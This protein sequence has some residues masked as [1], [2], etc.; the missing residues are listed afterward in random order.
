M[1]CTQK[2][3]DLGWKPKG[4]LLGSFYHHQAPYRYSQVSSSLALRTQSMTAIP[5]TLIPT[6]LSLVYRFSGSAMACRCVHSW[7]SDE[8]LTI[9]FWTRINWDCS[10]NRVEPRRHCR[11]VRPPRIRLCAR[12]NQ[13]VWERSIVRRCPVRRAGRRDGGASVL[14][15]A[16]LDFADRGWVSEGV[17]VP[18][19]STLC[20]PSRFSYYRPY[21]VRTLCR[22][23]AQREAALRD[24]IS[25][26][27]DALPAREGGRLSVRAQYLWLQDGLDYG[28]YFFK[29]YY[30]GPYR[31]VSLQ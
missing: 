15:V 16:L 8:L 6:S 27:G 31:D 22:H 4:A 20:A 26:R 17:D 29:I 13:Q 7:I 21:Q 10:G 1:P 23:C 12:A 24:S 18:R 11:K 14:Y 9:A 25:P 30:A 19:R 2:I 5:P 3:K 28:A